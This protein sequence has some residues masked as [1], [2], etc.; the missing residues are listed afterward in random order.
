MVWAR[1][2]ATA[3][4]NNL[5]ENQ[6]NFCKRTVVVHVRLGGEQKHDDGRIARRFESRLGLR[7][8]ARMSGGTR[9][10]II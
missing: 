3:H 6:E 7:D 4:S 10:R 5:T 8:G 2:E 1:S 9:Q